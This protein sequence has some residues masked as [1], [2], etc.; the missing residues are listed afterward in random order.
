MLGNLYEVSKKSQSYD[1]IICDIYTCCENRYGVLYFNNSKSISLS[2]I[3][4]I[5]V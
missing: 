5:I 1:I 3:V 4:N 2:E